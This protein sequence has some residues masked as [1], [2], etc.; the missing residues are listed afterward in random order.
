MSVP[1]IAAGAA[2]NLDEYERLLRAGGARQASVEDTLLVELAQKLAPVRRSPHAQVVS[3]ADPW[4]TGP[5]Q[6]PEAATPQPTIAFALRKPSGAATLDVEAEHA[7]AFGAPYSYDRRDA[8]RAKGRS[9]GGWTFKALALAPAGAALFSAALVIA[10]FGPKGGPS[11]APKAPPFIAAGQ[12]PTEAPQPSGETVAAQGDVDA[13]RLKDI[14]PVKVARSEERPSDR[15]AD[16][17]PAATSPAPPPAGEREPQASAGPP[18]AASATPVAAAEI[19]APPPA[20]WQSSD[21]SSVRTASAPP[22]ATAAPAAVHAGETA[23]RNAP[24]RPAQPAPS[25]GSKAVAVTQPTTSTLA[26]PA[27]LS[28]RASAGAMVAKTGAISPGPAETTSQHR[29]RGV[30]GPAGAGRA[31]GDP[32]ACRRSRSRQSDG[33]RLRRYGRRALRAGGRSERLGGPVRRA[34]IGSGSRGRR[35]AAQCQIRSGAQRGDD[36]RS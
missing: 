29:P 32:G 30:D 15:D 3:A 8:G 31:A 35:R 28:R 6:P 1:E 22:D 12:G 25:A 21:S 24:Q 11:G 16:A 23:P 10:V 26:L 27:N 4:D 36:R 34:K 13:A 20:V 5:M 33:A 19:A 7:S 17:S 9:P 14:A 2:N 18:V